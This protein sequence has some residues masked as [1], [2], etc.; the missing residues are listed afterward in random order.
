M[1]GTRFKDGIKVAVGGL[2]IGAQDAEVAVS[3]SAADLNKMAGVA[4][5]ATISGSRFVIS[6]PN[7][8][9]A[10]VAKPFWVAPAACKII[11]AT[12]RHITVSSNAGTLNLEKMIATK[13]TTAGDLLLGTGFNMT[14]TALTGVTQ[15]AVT[16][17][18]ATFEAGDTM[19]L[20]LTAATGTSYAGASLSVLMEW[21]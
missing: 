16:T 6:Y 19:G 20:I 7:F 8:A 10:D 18:V 5:G 15:A 17:A 12:E 1:A 11:S 14:S 21:L 3:A 4:A 13:A 2:K 9:L